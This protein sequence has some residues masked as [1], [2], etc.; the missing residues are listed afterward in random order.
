MK[1]EEISKIVREF[2]ENVCRIDDEEV[3]EV[4]E[5]CKRKI[6]IS[7]KTEDYM[8]FLL[9]DEL[10]HYCIRRA[11]NATTILRKMQKE[12]AICARCVGAIHA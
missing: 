8:E 5:L 4:I 2:R 7:G 11:I 10:K 3:E 9:P 12:G 6:F 1:K